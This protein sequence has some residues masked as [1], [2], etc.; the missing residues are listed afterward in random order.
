MNVAAALSVSQERMTW[1]ARTYLVITALQHTLI[2]IACINLSGTDA[3]SGDAWRIVRSLFPIWAWGIVFLCGGLHLAIAAARGSELL[4]RVGMP[5]SAVLTSLWAMSFILAW[6]EG[7]VVSPVGAILAAS[8]TAK[9]L[10][11]CR[12][13]MRSPF[14]P[15]VKEYVGPRSG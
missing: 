1:R 3:F 12:Q 8:L 10:V 7:G 14:E 13:P 4:A 5:L 11:I 2:G 15:L 6:H 9:D